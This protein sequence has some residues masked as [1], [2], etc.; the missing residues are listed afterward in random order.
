MLP[1][2][3]TFGGGAPG[4]ACLF[5]HAGSFVH[6]STPGNAGVVRG[7]LSP[8]VVGSPTMF[9]GV[10]SCWGFQVKMVL[11]VAESPLLMAPRQPSTS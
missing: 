10:R 8:A 5:V 2:P 6:L 1:L 3:T 4:G 9:V 7:L 11:N